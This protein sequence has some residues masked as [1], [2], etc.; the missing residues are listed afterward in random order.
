[1][2]DSNCRRSYAESPRPALLPCQPW[3]LL[4]WPVAYRWL[5]YSRMSGKHLSFQHFSQISTTN[6]RLLSLREWCLTRTGLGCRRH[7]A[8]R[9]RRLHL[10]L[11]FR[12]L[13]CLWRIA[14]A[15]LFSEDVVKARLDA[16]NGL[17]QERAPSRRRLVWRGHGGC[18]RR[19]CSA[20]FLDP[21]P[22]FVYGI[23]PWFFVVV[24][25]RIAVV[26]VTS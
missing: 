25:S 12:L 2:A 24:E 5:D 26:V 6:S 13:L 11:R 9:C 7:S 20:M 17:R 19:S 8:G 15:I 4:V 21:A 14:A 18:A 23:V 10:R 16:R 22:P 1:M 3:P